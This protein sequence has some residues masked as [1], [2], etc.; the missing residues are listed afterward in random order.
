MIHPAWHF[1]WY[2]LNKQGDNIL[3]WHASFSILNQS[4]V[5]CPL[6]TVASWPAYSF[7]RRQVRWPVI[8]TSLRIFQFV[9]IYTVKGLSVVNDAEVDI[10]SGILLLFLWSKGCWQF[11][12]WF[13]YISFPGGPD[14][15]ASDYNGGDLYSI[16]GLGKSPGEGNGDP[17]QYSCLE[18]HM[19]GRTWKAAALYIF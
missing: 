16:P 1:T 18:N 17:L 14:D 19:Y 5:P 11:D 12:L 8:T 6:L 4:I 3:S 10:F 9:V 15:K 2:K 13:L 7:L